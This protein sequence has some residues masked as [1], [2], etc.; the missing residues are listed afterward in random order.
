MTRDGWLYELPTWER[1]TDEH[2]SSS[3]LLTPTATNNGDKAAYNN[4]GEPLLAGQ[5][6]ALLP[7]PVV[8]DMGDGKTPEDWDIWTERMQAQTDNGNGHGKSLAIE[9]AR[10]LP[11]PAA[12]DAERGPDYAAETREGTGGDPLVTTIAKLLPTP[13]TSDAKGPS[14]SHAGTTAATIATL[15]G[16]SMNPPSPDTPPTSDQHHHHHPTIWDD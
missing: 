11:T 9:V 15:R 8:N 13:T 2:D 7:T 5:I 3:L 4:R 14:P 10:L 6:K 16:A 12:A 1:A